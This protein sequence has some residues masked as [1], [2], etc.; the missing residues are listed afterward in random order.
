MFFWELGTTNADGTVPT[1]QGI[2]QERRRQLH[3]LC[4]ARKKLVR[5]TFRPSAANGAPRLRAG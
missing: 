4:E 5:N 1:P 2:E 3:A